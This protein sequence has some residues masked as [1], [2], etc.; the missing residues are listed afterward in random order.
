VLFLRR[1]IVRGTAA[2]LKIVNSSYQGE[3]GEAAEKAIPAKKQHPNTRRQLDKTNSGQ[4]A[5]ST[6]LTVRTR[7]QHAGLNNAQLI[8]GRSLATCGHRTRQVHALLQS[9]NRNDQFDS[10]TELQK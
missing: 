7:A 9:D 6:L 8:P 5:E 4:W 2:R 10:I 1:T 3:E